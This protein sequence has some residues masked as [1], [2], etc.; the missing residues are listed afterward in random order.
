M[1]L[2]TQI[3]LHVHGFW[4]TLAFEILLFPPYPSIFLLMIQIRIVLDENKSF[5][6]SD[7]TVQGF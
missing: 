4:L 1:I 6:T 2:F 7:F 3:Q 5:V